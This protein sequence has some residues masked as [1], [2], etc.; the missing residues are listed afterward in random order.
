MLQ[1]RDGHSRSKPPRHRG[2]GGIA[3]NCLYQRLPEL[4]GDLEQR[5]PCTRS[6]RSHQC[7]LC[8]PAAK[9][10]V[11]PSHPRM[12]ELPA[13]WGVTPKAVLFCCAH[14]RSQAKLGS[15]AIPQ[16]PVLCLPSGP[17]LGLWWCRCSLRKSQQHW[18]PPPNQ[19]RGAHHSGSTRTSLQIFEQF[20]V[21][22]IC[23]KT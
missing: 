20:I 10:M 4:W 8:H 13:L 2:A 14:G 21:P 3:K 15:T 18:I 16:Y 6:H 12:L 5:H 7:S 1:G 9:K 11:P 22:G 23:T 19:T 17:T